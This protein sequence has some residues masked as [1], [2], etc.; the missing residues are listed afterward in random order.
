MNPATAICACGGRFGLDVQYLFDARRYCVL[1]Q[2]PILW[3]CRMCGRSLIDQ[4][5]AVFEA[6]RE[7]AVRRRGHRVRRHRARRLAATR[8]PAARPPAREIDRY[9][10]FFGN[11]VETASPNGAAERS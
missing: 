6:S 5:S 11:G 8:P 7:H 3:R 10:D 9:I 2:V 1:G 4:H